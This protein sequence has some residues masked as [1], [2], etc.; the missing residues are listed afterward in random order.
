VGL[1]SFPYGT[2]CHAHAWFIVIHGAEIKHT[3]TLKEKPLHSHADDPYRE[4]EVTQ[5]KICNVG[6]T[7]DVSS[8]PACQQRLKKWYSVSAEHRF[9]ISLSTTNTACHLLCGP[10]FIVGCLATTHVTARPCKHF[11]PGLLQWQN[12]SSIDYASLEILASLTITPYLHSTQVL[13]E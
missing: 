10:G 6:G 12:P 1:I 5:R 7:Q 11:V 4:F 2:K 13:C 9:V 3:S 8:N